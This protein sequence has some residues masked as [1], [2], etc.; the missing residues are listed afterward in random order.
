MFYFFAAGEIDEESKQFLLL[1]LFF[2][3]QRS[4]LTGVPARDVEP[5]VT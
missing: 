3:W 2:L 1:L 5:W 4:P